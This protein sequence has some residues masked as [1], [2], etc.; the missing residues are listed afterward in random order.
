MDL[1]EARVAEQCAAAMRAPDGGAVR[2]LR[3]GREVEDV[4]VTAGGEYDDVTDVRLDRARLQIARDDA[5][6][7]AVHDHEIEHLAA[8]MHRD[9]AGGDLAL[10][11]LVCAEQE[12][13]PCLPARVERALDLNA[14]KGPRLEQAAVV[15]GERHALGDTLVDD[16]DADLRQ[17]IGVGLAGA[18][19]AALDGVL[20][21]AVDAVAVVA[22]V[23]GGIDAALGGDRVGA[24]RRVVVREALHVIALLAE[25]G[26]GGGAGEARA[27]DQDGVLAP[28]RGVHQVHLEAAAVPFLFDQSCGNSR[29]EY[30][31]HRSLLQRTHPASTATG[32]EMNPTNTASATA[33]DRVLSVEV[34]L[35]LFQPSVW[36]RLQ[37]P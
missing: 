37:I 8:V 11:R 32:T 7:L 22:V 25:R 27:D 9:R 29:V 5:A 30:D 28:V 13:L 26:G 17:A 15:A 33:R 6:R 19:V 1:R 18:E 4:T 12:L 16:V 35:A 2:S 24:A 20:E 14:A 31:R 34:V 21:Q 23:L 36:S 10:E 3:V